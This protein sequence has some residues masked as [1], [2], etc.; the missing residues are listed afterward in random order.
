ME[1]GNP[2]NADQ[3]RRER[4]MHTLRKKFYAALIF[5]L[6]LFYIAMGPMVKLPVPRFMDPHHE[7][8][9]NAIVQLI[10]TVPVMIIGYKFYTSGFSKLFRREPN[11]DSL[12]AVG[13]S[14]AFIYS[15]FTLFETING[16][17]TGHDLYFESAAVI[18]TLILLGKLRL[19][20]RDELRMR[21]R[22]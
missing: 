21:S 20:R 7:P 2:L 10:L 16:N 19:V 3:E 9:T 4:T 8:V 15:I 11:M 6:P 17:S 14:A 5:T 18:I 12:I 13:T 1:V 22:N